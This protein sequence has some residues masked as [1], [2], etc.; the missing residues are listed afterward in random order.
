MI[1]ITA[2]F[3]TGSANQILWQCRQITPGVAT[4]WWVIPPNGI[5]FTFQ[6]QPGLA[7]DVTTT[8]SV[9]NVG[10]FQRTYGNIL[11]GAEADGTSWRAIIRR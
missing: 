6:V 4:N 3:P 7:V 9:D 8:S 5:P 2:N 10:G 11:S 1:T